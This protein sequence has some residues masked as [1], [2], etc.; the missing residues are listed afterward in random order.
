MTPLRL[1][2]LTFPLCAQLVETVP[3][4]PRVAIP[5][6]S[7]KVFVPVVSVRM[8]F[9]FRVKGCPK[10]AG[11]QRRPRKIRAVPKWTIV[12]PVA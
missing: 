1:Q 12:R 8:R 2:T 3:R 5:A 7:T 4:T 9:P 10:M 11:S 6:S